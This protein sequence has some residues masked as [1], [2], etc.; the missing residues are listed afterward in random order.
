[1]INKLNWV[2]ST[3]LIIVLML[4]STCRASAG[5]T[6]EEIARFRKYLHD[7]ELGN[8]FAQ[9]NLGLCYERGVGVNADYYSAVKWYRRSAE[10]DN[11]DGQASLAGCYYFGTGVMKDKVE[12]Y[13]YYKLASRTMEKARKPL[14]ELR[15]ELS[16]F[17][18]AQAEQ[19][20]RER[21]KVIGTKA[22]SSPEANNIDRR[23][24]VKD[25]ENFRQQAING[26][27]EGQFNLATCYR[28]GIGVTKN[29]TEAA[30]W[31]R[32]SAEQ[33]F[34]NSQHMLGYCYRNDIGVTQDL[35][36]AIK[37]YRKAAN[38]GFAHAQFALG[39]SYQRGEGVSKDEGEA[40][41]WYKKA[42]DQGF[43][44][45][46][47]Q[48]GRMYGAGVGV[49][50]SY[51]QSL[52]WYRKAAAQGHLDAQCYL[53]QFYEDG[54]NGVT[55][56]PA[57]AVKWFRKSAEYGHASS[58]SWLGYCYWKGIGVEENF[59]EACGYYSL[60]ARSGGEDGRHARNIIGVMMVNV[61]P[62]SY[63]AELI[64]R[65]EIRAQQLK[66]EFEAKIAAKKA[67]R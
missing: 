39:V 17:E 49:S 34:P 33:G 13:V 24:E 32:I 21:Q 22:V 66:E 54:S 41:F 53:G 47:F 46:Q 31:Y 2:K 6:A 36:E 42:A 60:A 64:K 61:Y 20:V 35:D 28:D 26:D 10:Q 18:F 57:E 29:H 62:M 59:E 7:A 48:L 40:V 67:G 44:D 5:V 1:M 9:Y 51:E 27:A 12:A 52:K 38:Q 4:A 23:K 8:P 56:D 37:W 19:K 63:R 45:A 15:S 11:A 14:E 3:S 25:F 50:I 30:R 43:S 16:L 58:L 65:G 55:K